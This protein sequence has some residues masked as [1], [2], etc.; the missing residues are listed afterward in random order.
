MV[1]FFRFSCEACNYSVVASGQ[2][3]RESL[4]AG[5]T[6]LCEDCKQLYE[7]EPE[8]SYTVKVKTSYRMLRCPKAYTHKIRVWT[9]PGVCPQCGKPMTKGEHVIR[10][11]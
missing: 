11:D 1:N 9:F 3:G 4:D 8:N 10:W 6:I 5:M 7:I 2:N